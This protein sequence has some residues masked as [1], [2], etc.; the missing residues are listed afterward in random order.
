MKLSSNSFLSW[1]VALLCVTCCSGSASAA[2]VDEITP[3]FTAQHF[4]WKEYYGGRRL[5]D[6][7]GPLFSGGAK[8]GI[9]TDFAMTIKAKAEVFGGIIN[10]DGETQAPTPVPV[11]TD[12]TY[13]GT[14][15]EADLGYRFPI[16][17]VNLEPFAG[18]G[19]RWWTRMLQDSHTATGA[20]VSGYTETWDTLYC[21]L[22][23]RGSY[24]PDPD[25]MVYAEGGGKY[26]FYT[27]NSVDFVNF[28]TVTFHPGARWSGFAEAGVSYRHF[29]VA[30]TY[31]GFKW[32]ESPFKA[33]GT[34]AFF[35]PESTSQIMGVS[36]G[37]NFK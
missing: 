8:V 33:V 26:P 14:R 19:Y 37:W 32:S 30:F 2:K 5:L 22:G 34:Q 7:D 4:T 6:E 10:Y 31:E 23:G 24:R 25:W 21:R 13:V 29:K 17:H 36:L 15:G 28:G 1:I 18:L 20:P 11:T 16:Q 35:Q 9:L 3:F 27:G 12:V